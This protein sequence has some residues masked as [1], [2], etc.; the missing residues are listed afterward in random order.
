MENKKK[1][2]PECGSP[3]EIL[4]AKF[5]FKCGAPISLAGIK[6]KNEA[7]VK[8]TQTIY[9]EEEDGF[10]DLPQITKVEAEIS[11]G[12]KLK[13]GEIAATDPN[14]EGRGF[15][16]KAADNYPTNTKDLFGMIGEEFKTKRI[17][18]DDES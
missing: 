14:K 17:D 11:I 12:H 18:F 10:D 4:N 9:M 6:K 3:S 8:K 5:C 7:N 1:Y 2:C 16:R 13:L 15:K